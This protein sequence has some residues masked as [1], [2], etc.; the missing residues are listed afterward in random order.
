MGGEHPSRQEKVDQST[1][2]EQ[3]LQSWDAMLIDE[4]TSTSVV[5]LARQGRLLRESAGSLT[6]VDLSW[7]DEAALSLIDLAVERGQ[8]LRLVYPVPAGELAVLLA[9][10][11]LLHRF[12]QGQSSA[13]GLVTADP[14]L[15]SRTWEELRI[16]APGAREPITGVFPCY[17]AGPGGE[18]PWGRREFRGL[19]V[20]QRAR[21]WKVDVLIEDHIAGPVLVEDGGATVAIFADPLDPSLA[22]SA[23][24]GDL[25]WA[26]SEGQLAYWNETLETRAQRTGAFS[27]SPSR[28][29]TMAEGVEVSIKRA[30]HPHAEDAAMR[31]R[32]DLRV[33]REASGR[34]P[35]RHM[36]KGLGVAW[37]HFSTLMSLPCKPSLFDRH[38]G[39]PPWAARS[40]SLFER[41]I[42]TW[43]STL[44]GDERE[45][46]GI[47]ASDLGDLRAAFEE[48][49]PY[50]AAIEEAAGSGQDHLLVVKTRTAARGLL[51]MLN[52][53][54]DLETVER[55]RIST[56]RKLHREEA[57]RRGL[58]IGMPAPWD[59]HRLDSGLASEVSVVVLGDAEARMSAA[60]A[61]RVQ[62]E[63]ERWA[64][65]EHRGRTWTRL[66]G[67]PAPPE[68]SIALASPRKL[69]EADVPQSV[70]EEDPFETLGSLLTSDV[71]SIGGEGVEEVVARETEDGDW[72]AAV[73]AVEVVTDMGRI[74]LQAGRP[75]E[76]RDGTRITDK[77]PESLTAGVF[78]LIGRRH[79]RLGLLEALEE[80]LR[81]RRPDLLASRLVIENYRRQVQ[82]RFAESG[83][84]VA[85]LHRA[86]SDRGCEKTSQAVKSWVLPD[87]AMAPRDFADLR[88]LNTE[89]SIGLSDVYLGEIF[90]AV[91]R[92]RGFR[93]SAGRALAEAARTS[94]GATDQS[95]IDPDTG[96]S[97]ADLQEAVVEAR[98][99]AVSACAE[100]VPLTELGRLENA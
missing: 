31:V 9:A 61:R 66:V 23:S 55:L 93:R 92:R 76:V 97:I 62:E 77:T 91:Q 85:D 58:V 21:A 94:M 13:V 24:Q 65:T 6:R 32:E 22:R 28:L 56:W 86:L 99:L 95:R 73:R 89:L 47:L 35:T 54:P 90:A 68:P 5:G 84:S 48:S 50:Q 42:A 98:V 64:A 8:G 60:M 10:Q 36:A 17:R 59:W 1:A 41:E 33:L 20:G 45:L 11:L 82:A 78:L 70:E 15:A 26:W 96:L 37:H 87:G 40:T 39:V 69:F 49:N 83:R 67:T 34:T 72:T 25:V 4:Q 63:R 71:L 51:T 46:A 44:S 3:G 43:A 18:S 38:A 30:R 75:I 79:G 88:L 29:K 100:P 16:R 57:C 27:V 19:L 7:V 52:V 14:T 80:R 53:D 12:R 74:R 2:A 81:H